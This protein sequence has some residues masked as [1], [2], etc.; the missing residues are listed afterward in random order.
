MQNQFIGLLCLFGWG[1][2]RGGEHLCLLFLCQQHPLLVF[3]IHHI[4]WD[5]PKLQ[6]EGSLQHCPQQD[7]IH[8]SVF[9]P[10]DS[11]SDIFFFCKT[12]QLKEVIK[13]S[14]AAKNTFVGL[15]VSLTF[16]FLLNK[17]N[18]TCY[19]SE[20]N[21]VS[22]QVGFILQRPVITAKRLHSW[23]WLHPTGMTPRAIWPTRHFRLGMSAASAVTWRS[24]QKCS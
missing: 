23:V 11:L 4:W 13:N 16:F 17:V 9:H 3:V 1:S 8:K 20:L 21:C 10:G 22:C 5:G 18:N 24:W 19:H 7:M 2:G 15:I 6:M 12:A 14:E